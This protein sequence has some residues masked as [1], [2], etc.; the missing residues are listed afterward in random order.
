MGYRHEYIEKLEKKIDWNFV[1]TDAVFTH[2]YHKLTNYVWN[3]FAVSS[4]GDIIVTQ[5]VVQI[6]FALPVQMHMS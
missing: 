1:S 6:V 4:E 2:R 3:D 5:F